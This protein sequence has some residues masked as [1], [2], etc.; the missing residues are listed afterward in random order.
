MKT[1][2]LVNSRGRR[3][4]LC[5]IIRVREEEKVIIVGEKIS[6]GSYLGLKAS[7]NWVHSKAKEE[8]THDRVAVV[9]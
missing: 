4:C 6:V 2:F 7:G 9:M 5:Y 1:D 3:Q 8:G